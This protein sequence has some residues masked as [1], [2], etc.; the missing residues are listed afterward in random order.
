MKRGERKRGFKVYQ[1][2]LTQGKV[3]RV[4][5][6]DYKRLSQYKWYYGGDKNPYAV[7]NVQ[8]PKGKRLE[9]MHRVILEVEE[10]FDVDHRDTDGLNNCRYNLRKC[11]RGQNQINKSKQTGRKTTSKYKGVYFRKDIGRFVAEVIHNK[12]REYVGYFDTE[13]EAGI[14]YNENALRIHGEF[15]RLNIIEE[16]SDEKRRA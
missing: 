4:S 11:T 13:L 3:A 10:G 2:P 16:V 8:T 9:Y 14:A 15:A 7:R 12:K 1:I 5:P 6:V